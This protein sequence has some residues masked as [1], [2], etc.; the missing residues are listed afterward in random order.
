[1]ITLR[2][3]LRH[4]ASV[5][6]PLTSRQ[7][8]RRDRG[9]C[10]HAR[11]AFDSSKLRFRTTKTRRRHSLTFRVA[12]GGATA[13][14]FAPRWRANRARRF[15]ACYGPRTASWFTPPGGF[16]QKYSNA[17]PIPP[18]HYPNENSYDAYVLELYSTT[19]VTTQPITKYPNLAPAYP[20]LV[21]TLAGWIWTLWHEPS[22]H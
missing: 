8:I 10:R 13:S 4:D 11:R 3:A 6:R 22:Q 1:M 7:H 18:S 2:A 15:A 21:A 5:V 19:V 12:I 16:G 9:L 14:D 17:P 20:L